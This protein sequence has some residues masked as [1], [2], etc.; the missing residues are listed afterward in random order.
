MLNIIFLMGAYFVIKII[1]SPE[2]PVPIGK[3]CYWPGE[4]G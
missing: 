2:I 3:Q 1:A 4:L